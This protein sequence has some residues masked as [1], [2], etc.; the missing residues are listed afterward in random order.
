[1]VYDYVLAH[2]DTSLPTLRELARIFGTNEFKLKV[3]FKYLFK[4]SIHKLHTNERLERAHLLIENTGLPLKE[5]A[6]RVGYN[7]YPSFSRAFKIKY[8]YTPNSI[9]RKA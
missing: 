4:T 1:M 5:I 2:K 3:G 9:L 6:F 7:S 8:R